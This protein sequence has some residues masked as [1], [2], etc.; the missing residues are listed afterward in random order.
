MRGWGRELSWMRSDAAGINR[1]L[2]IP[3]ALAG[4]GGIPLIGTFP[5]LHPPLLQMK[6]Q[7]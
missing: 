4:P 6:R 5:A 3:P 1:K 2:F 7:V